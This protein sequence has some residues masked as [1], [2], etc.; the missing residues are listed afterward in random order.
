MNRN[1]IARAFADAFITDKRADGV[2]FVRLADG[3]PEWMTE[4][5]RAAHCDMMPEDTR[6]SMI[7]ECADALADRDAD[8]WEDSTG[9]IA[10]GLVDVYNNARLTWLASNLHRAAYCDEAQDEG[11][12]SDKAS[13]FDRIGV[14][15]YMEYDEILRELVQA[16]QDRADEEEETD[17]ESAD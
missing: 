7:R 16:F 17:D 10:D 9:E 14:G 2:E 1:Q 6:Y 8:E 5:V 4:A 12:V 15:Q 13:M 3:S 11:L